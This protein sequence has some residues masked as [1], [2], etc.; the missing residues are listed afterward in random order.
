MEDRN[1]TIL[2][3]NRESDEKCIRVMKIE[4]KVMQITVNRK[5]T[6]YKV[7]L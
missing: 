3:F 1:D 4:T 7:L 2:R 6:V 5:V